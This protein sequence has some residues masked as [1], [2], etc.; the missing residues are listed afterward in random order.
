MRRKR[1]TW[2]PRSNLDTHHLLW[3]R[4]AWNYGP[5]RAL[6]DY[7]YCQIRIPREGLHH[8]IHEEVCKIPVPELCLCEDCL[9]QLRLLEKANAI[10]ENDPIE[11]RLEI[12]ICCLDTGDSP[13]ADALKHQLEAVKAYKPE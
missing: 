8:F 9:K 3:T 5:A 2:R 6:R 12:L 11:K 1:R 13:T 7:W 10:H 4:R